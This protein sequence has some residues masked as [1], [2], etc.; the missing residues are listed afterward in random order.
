MKNVAFIFPG[1]G[2]QY[3]GMGKEI[4][5]SFTQ[6]KAVFD[7]AN[8]ILG[9]DLTKLCFE[10][11]EDKLR[12]TINCQPAIFTLSIACLESF[13]SQSQYKNLHPKFM[14]GLSLGEYSALVAAGVFS[15]ED[16]LK[17]VRKRAE[18]MEEDAN[19]IPG[20]MVAVL[21]ENIEEVKSICQASG[22]RIANLNCPGQVVISGKAVDI[23]SAVELL[24][25]RGYRSVTLEVNGAFHCDLMK[26]AADKLSV[27]LKR[28]K[29]QKPQVPVI[30]NVTANP[31]AS[32]EEIKSNLGRQVSSPVLWEESVRYMAG[33][34]I[35]E[36]LEIGPGQVLKGMLRR[37]D[38]NLKVYNVEKPQDIDNLPL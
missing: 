18:F 2:S 20:K 8:K 3:V 37:I 29:M 14:A 28:S 5:E 6:A 30:S 36:F 1:Q 33:E 9:F 32:V 16:G 17:I 7:N 35:T 38:A 4:Y 22:A 13:K 31:E 34:G 15:F 27:L 10:G 11:P 12:A 24:E 19:R 25:Q 26:I 21:G 23:D